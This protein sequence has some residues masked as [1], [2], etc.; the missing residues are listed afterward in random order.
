MNPRRSWKHRISLIFTGMMAFVLMTFAAVTP[1]FASEAS[2]VI[3]PTGDESVG[4]I[5][6][7]VGIAIIALVVLVAAVV[8]SRRR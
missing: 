3:S 5:I 4:F 7:I 8:L 2:S 1:A 6:M